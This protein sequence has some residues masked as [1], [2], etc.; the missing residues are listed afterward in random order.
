MHVK[1]LRTSTHF[2]HQYMSPLAMLPSV[3]F[4]KEGLYIFMQHSSKHWRGPPFTSSPHHH[5]VRVEIITIYFSSH[6][7]HPT[8]IATSFF[9]SICHMP[10]GGG[11][12][13]GGAVVEVWSQSMSQSIFSLAIQQWQRPWCNG[14]GG[15]GGLFAALGK[16]QLLCIGGKW[17]P[18]Q[19]RGDPPHSWPGI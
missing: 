5:L 6:S 2:L 10:W 17:W 9:N 19:T 11:G 13:G 14:V 7:F 12:Q 18:F 8:F 16:L 1:P 3:L 15:I 4:Y